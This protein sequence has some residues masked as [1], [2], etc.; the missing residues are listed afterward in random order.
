MVKYF[1]DICDR[2]SDK[3][4]LSKL[5][6]SMHNVESSRMQEAIVYSEICQACRKAILSTIYDCKNRPQ[7]CFGDNLKGE[8]AEPSRTSK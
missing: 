4:D 8:R 2:Q 6:I 7:Q 1:C 3:M 5:A